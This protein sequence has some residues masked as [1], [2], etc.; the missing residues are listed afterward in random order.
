MYN[1]EVISLLVVFTTTLRGVTSE[2]ILGDTASAFCME[3]INK[4]ITEHSK[5]QSIR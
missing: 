4:I 5:Q 2:I 3:T 1:R